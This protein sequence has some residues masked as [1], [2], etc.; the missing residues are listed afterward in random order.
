[1]N[2]PVIS[3]YISGAVAIII[4]I[5]H[6]VL[7]ETQVFPNARIEPPQTRR[8]LH[9]VWQ[10]G[11]AAWLAGGILLLASPS[12]SDAL[13]RHWIIIA[14]FLIYGVAAVFNAIASRG[15]HFGWMVLAAVVVFA[16]LG[17]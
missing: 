12:L 8:L 15:H 2:I 4:A 7:A 14:A 6:G 16:A 3:L 5:V 11:T 10:A 17:W 1:M 9:L 13:A